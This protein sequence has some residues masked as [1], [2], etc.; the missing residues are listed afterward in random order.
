[1]ADN[2]TFSTFSNLYRIDTGT[3]GLAAS[4]SGQTLI[5]SPIVS[6]QRPEIVKVPVRGI[7]YVNPI[8]MLQYRCIRELP[9]MS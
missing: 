2:P 9:N 3:G 5:K 6:F 4:Y 1:M 7:K 8:G